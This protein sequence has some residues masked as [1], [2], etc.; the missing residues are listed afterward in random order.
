MHSC[1]K[2]VGQS[3]WM[4]APINHVQLLWQINTSA[5]NMASYTIHYKGRNL[6]YLP[7]SNWLTCNQHVVLLFANAVF[8]QFFYLCIWGYKNLSTL[9]Y[10]I[11]PADAQLPTAA[12][13]ME[14]NSFLSALLAFYCNAEYL[15]L[16]HSVSFL[17]TV[18][19]KMIWSSVFP[20]WG[21]GYHSTPRI[22]LLGV[23]PRIS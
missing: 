7:S 14:A 22:L 2:S 17:C 12:L 1:N 19:P 15:E 23:I 10:Q 20:A 11:G 16:L 18:T 13:L 4:E 3:P 21:F 9:S 5:P 8:F 6:N